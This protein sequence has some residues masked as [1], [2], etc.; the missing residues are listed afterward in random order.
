M[1]DAAQGRGFGLCPL[2]DGL[3]RGCDGRRH[4][5][6]TPSRRK[7]RAGRMCAKKASLRGAKD[8]INGKNLSLEPKNRPQQDVF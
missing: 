8:A 2:P 6:H 7:V 3:P 4:G 5:E 1:T